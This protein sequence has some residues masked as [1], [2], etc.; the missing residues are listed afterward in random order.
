MLNY[1]LTFI[2]GLI[3][4]SFFN[5]VIYRLPRGES[6]II[7]PS[8]CPSCNTRLKAV[9]L[10]PVLSYIIY[11]GKCRYCGVKIS[12]QYPIV[13]LLTAILYLSVYI[14][15]GFSLEGFI[16]LFLISLLIIISFID[17]NEKIIPNLLSYSGIIIGLILSL[18]FNH[19]SFISAILGLIIPSL[20]LLIIALIFQGGMGIG[21]VKLV[22]MI[23]TFTGYLYPMIGI[24][25]G[26]L[27]GSIIFLPLLMT[28]KID[29]KTRIPFGPLISLGTIIM[30]LFGER[31]IDLY[32]S[33]LF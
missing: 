7:P 30:I 26:A 14:K 18:I 33:F 25:I 24:F 22:G 32:W 31:L 10:I 29:K 17:L 6:V 28:G 11:R 21:D 2:T 13:E 16:Y 8:H 27:V 1:A 3:I 23:G 20:L 15:F 9:D 19:I 4:G 5:V 12:L